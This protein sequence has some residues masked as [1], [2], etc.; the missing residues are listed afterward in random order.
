MARWRNGEAEDLRRR[1]E[2]GESAETIATAI[3]RP[4]GEV[5]D[6]IS[7][8]R[9]T[10]RLPSPAQTHMLQAL[11][12]AGG[13]LE[14]R[15]ERWRT[16]ESCERRGWVKVLARPPF[17]LYYTCRLTDGGWEIGTR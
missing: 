11:A 13:E 14:V 2:L 1:A 4:L 7:S 3:S 8:Y 12:S 6:R 5:L 15:P 10:G 9:R 17:A 16:V